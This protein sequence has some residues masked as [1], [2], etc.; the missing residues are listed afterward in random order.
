MNALCING[1]RCNVA[2]R[3]HLPPSESNSVADESMGSVTDK[4]V[5]K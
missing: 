2:S 1:V 5:N 4:F 3:A